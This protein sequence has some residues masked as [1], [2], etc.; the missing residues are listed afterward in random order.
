MT[1]RDGPQS[2]RILRGDER[3]IVHLHG[4]WRDPESVVLGIGSYEDV[5]RDTGAQALLQALATYNSFLLVG[6]GKGLGDPNFAALRAWMATAHGNSE[7]RHYRLVLDHEVE[8]IA[9]EH[10]PRE[11]ITPISYGA[12]HADLAGFLSALGSNAPREGAARVAGAH[13]TCDEVDRAAERRYREVALRAFDRI[14]LANLPVDRHVAT[15]NLM[16]RR[17]YVALQVEVEAPA[18][19]ELGEAHLL[20]LEQRRSGRMLGPVP[21]RGDESRRAPVGQRLGATRRL[22]VLG[23]PG[24]GKTTLLRWIATVYLL[25]L[26]QHPDAR[27][28]P[29]ADTLPDQDW[30]PVLVRCRDLGEEAGESVDAALRRSL[31]KLELPPN[32]CDAVLQVVRRRLAAGTALVLVD[33]LDEIADRALRTGF[34]Q[35]LER[36]HDAYPDSPIV[37]TSRIVGYRELGARIGRGFEHVTVA[38]LTK[39]DKDDFARRWCAL[40][41]LPAKAEDG[42]ICDLHATPRIEELT[43]NPMLLTTM[44]L[45]RW[46]I[47]KLPSRRADLYEEAV[48]VLLSWRSEVDDPLDDAEAL[49]QLRYLA[50]AMCDRGIQQLREDEAIDLL[51]ELRASYEQLRRVRRREPEDFLRLLERRTAIVKQSG[52]V[53]TTA[54][55]CRSMSSATSPSRSTWRVSRW[56]ARSFRAPTQAAASLSASSR[57][58]HGSLYPRLVR[59]VWAKAGGSHCGCASPPVMTPTTRCWPSSHRRLARTPLS[60]LG[61]VRSRPHAA[62]RTSPTSPSRSRTRRCAP[63]SDTSTPATAASEARRSFTPPPA[64]S[65]ALIGAAH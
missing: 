25:R 58:P 8:T 33:G 2:Q 31:R 64:S 6:F 43:G 28:L 51:S 15:R 32:Q 21:I 39:A 45:V 36:F 7:Y 26:G 16:L 9:A 19:A 38:E 29:D 48:R 10:D 65:R 61:R 14:D 59:R 62:W 63:S 17:L 49:P 42:L 55:S 40:A 57:S 23:D 41:G 22:V 12:R 3:G 5:L 18:G 20:E 53:R 4:H 34:C 1:W 54:S 27:A 50:Y 44:A 47:G 46:R 11:R 24:A 37:V 35:Q 30:L 13:Q 60:P 52:E 56:S